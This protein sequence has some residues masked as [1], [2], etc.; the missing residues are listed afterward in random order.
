MKKPGM[1]GYLLHNGFRITPLHNQTTAKANMM[2]PNIKCSLFVLHYIDCLSQ[3]AA[4]TPEV[5]VGLT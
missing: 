2:E 1:L 3:F 4:C 5:H